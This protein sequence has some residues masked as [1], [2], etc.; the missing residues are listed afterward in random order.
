MT[1]SELR[2]SAAHVF[3]DD[4]ERPELS[5]DDVHHLTRVLRLRA[6]EAV[7]L[8]DGD[9]RWRAG[10]FDSGRVEPSGAIVAVPGAEPALAVGFGLLK[11]DRSELVTQK[12][13][14]LG[15]DLICP[16]V[17]ARCVVRQDPGNRSRLEARLQRVAREA[18]MQS[19][20]VRIPVVAPISTW[21]DVVGLAGWVRADLG[22]A[23]PG[24]D[25]PA[26]LVGPEGG[27]DDAEQAAVPD[28][29]S[30]GPN[31]LRAE[32][33]AVAAITVLSLL[34]ARMILPA[35]GM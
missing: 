30:L 14:E 4:L 7:T 27:W 29:V 28:S 3:V 26:I 15:A 10:R 19:R 24:L 13:T 1:G 18:S 20:R 9:G 12:L 25:R 6:G 22:G 31:V 32:T 5:D 17:S 21:S 35:A 11:G 33:A 23:P 34:R 16:F 8:S 2:T